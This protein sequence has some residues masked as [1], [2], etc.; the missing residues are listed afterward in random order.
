MTAKV[1]IVDRDNANI[2]SLKNALNYVGTCSVS[3]SSDPEQIKDSDFIV[4]AG[5]GA[6]GDGMS[7]LIRKNL[8]DILSKEVLQNK[9][10]FLG[11]CLGMQMLFTSSSEKGNHKGLNF[12]EG[13]VDYLDLP[14]NFRVP[15]LGWN[16]IEYSQNSKVF[17]NLS[18]D[19]NFY[20][21][22]SF[23]ATCDK[24]NIIAEVDYGQKITAAVQL[25]NILGFQFHPEKSQENGMVLLKNFLSGNYF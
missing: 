19:R 23:H 18:A 13:T 14:N 8:I 4:L 16:N 25:D 15:H 22:H 2:N 17:K 12:I 5:V 1:V 3:V 21:V 9:K 6:F 10:P 11:I 24:K 7:D 20:F